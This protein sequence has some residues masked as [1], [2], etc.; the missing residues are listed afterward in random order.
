MKARIWNFGL[1]TFINEDCIHVF[2]LLRRCHCLTSLLSHDDDS[3]RRAQTLGI[4]HLDA[5]LD[6]DCYHLMVNM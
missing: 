4:H 1:I 3:G 2:G 6:W 5:N